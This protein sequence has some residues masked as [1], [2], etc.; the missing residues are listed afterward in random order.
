M[1][2]ELVRCN[3]NIGIFHINAGD[4]LLFCGNVGLKPTNKTFPYHSITI[5]LE[6]GDVRIVDKSSILKALH[7]EY[8]QYVLRIDSSFFYSLPK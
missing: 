1:P 8:G 2:A 5:K 4:S 3:G 6:Q 7:K